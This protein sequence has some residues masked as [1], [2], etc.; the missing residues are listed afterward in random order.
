MPKALEI[1]RLEHRALATMLR[2]LSASIQ[3]PQRGAGPPPSVL[4][5]AMRFYI[6]EFPEKR[7]HHKE[8][9]LLFPK[10]RA[11][12][13][14]HRDLLDRLDE[15]HHLGEV[16]IR[17]LEHALLGYEVMGEARRAA[18]EYTAGRYVDFY[19]THMGLEE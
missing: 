19:L 10:L 11:R 15:E 13:P 1:I 14:R 12:S 8:T 18:F 9:E 6:D 7:H 2:S 16:R 3:Q 5:R 4:L 17:E